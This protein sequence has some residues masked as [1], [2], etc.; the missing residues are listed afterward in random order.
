MSWQD[1]RRFPCSD[2]DAIDDGDRVGWS[3]FRTLHTIQL[4]VATKVAPNG[5]GYLQ[6][7]P[8]IRRSVSQILSGDLGSAGDDKLAHGE[9]PRCITRN[10]K[11]VSAGPLLI[12]VWICKTP[13]WAITKVAEAPFSSPEKLTSTISSFGRVLPPVN[14]TVYCPGGQGVRP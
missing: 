10:P 12:E 7:D 4:T 14:L 6:T 3:P 1:G 8:K 13:E 2:P 11:P 9:E 5:S